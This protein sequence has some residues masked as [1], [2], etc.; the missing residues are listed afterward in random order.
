[1]KELL[2]NTYCKSGAEYFDISGEI[3]GA[4]TG[5]P[6]V[7]RPDGDFIGAVEIRMTNND[8]GKGLFATENIQRGEA[9]VI[10]KALA[11]CPETHI[12]RYSLLHIVR[13][14]SHD[15]GENAR[16]IFLA[17]FMTNRSKFI[18]KMCDFVTKS[19]VGKQQSDWSQLE[20]W[21][22]REDGLLRS[23]ALCVQ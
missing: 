18:P 6:R 3:V 5:R 23:T 13:D 19:S 2:T 12:N 10:S 21:S 20:G 11:V 1:M 16:R 22:R 14:A 4:A 8:C 9:L 7:V 17:H 15:C